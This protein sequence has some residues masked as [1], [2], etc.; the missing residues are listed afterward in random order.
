MKNIKD[1]LSI[2]EAKTS[3]WMILNQKVIKNIK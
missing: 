1:F 3:I 2:N